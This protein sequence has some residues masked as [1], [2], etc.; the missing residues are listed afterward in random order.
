MPSIEQVIAAER[1]ELMK[2][3]DEGVYKVPCR[4]V[5]ENQ[6]SKIN[7]MEKFE[8]KLRACPMLRADSK[9]TSG[10]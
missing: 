7:F 1:R 5:D 2:L 3:M 6:P 9:D 8:D 10:S 4:C